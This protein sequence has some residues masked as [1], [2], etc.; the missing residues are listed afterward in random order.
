MFSQVF[1][2]SIR[3]MYARSEQKSRPKVP[4]CPCVPT[5]VRRFQDQVAKTM[6]EKSRAIEKHIEIALGVPELAVD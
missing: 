5:A 4:Y 6:R 1:R 3:P 2:K